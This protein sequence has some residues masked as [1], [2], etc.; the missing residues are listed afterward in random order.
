MR[1]T[2]AAQT[3]RSGGLAGSIPQLGFLKQS[4]DQTTSAEK[5][6]ERM[7]DLEQ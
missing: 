2:A 6:A 5:S 3:D 1:N 7:S 4:Q